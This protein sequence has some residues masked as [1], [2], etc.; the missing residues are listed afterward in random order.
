[1][2]GMIGKH[3]EENG[4]NFIKS[5]VPTKLEKKD[6]KILV[7]WENSE[8]KEIHTGEFDTVL[9][10]IGRYALTEG[11][12][13]GNAGVVAEKNGKI[14]A[15]DCEQTNVEN[16]FAIGDVLY[17]N[18]ELTPTAIKAGKLLA[19]RLFAGATQKMDY[20]NVP[21]TVFTPLEYGTCGL[22]EADA[23]KEFGD[24]NIEVFHQQF[25]P[26]E[27]NYN[28][29][30]KGVNGYTKVIVHTANN[31]KIVGFHI[32]APNAGDITQ[33]VGIAMQNPSFN[34]DQLDS[35]VGIHPTVAEDIIGLDKTKREEPDATKGSC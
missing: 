15:N 17:G 5:S 29:K 13:L 10:A 20:V 24:E 26:L 30:R 4:V 25:K 2:A 27:W 16:I 11:I 35:C 6:D 14:K 12:N 3:M 32:L 31:N 21:T 7:S 22:S 9:F 34:K 1:M 23:I 18:L 33:G 28:R 8:T 19:Q